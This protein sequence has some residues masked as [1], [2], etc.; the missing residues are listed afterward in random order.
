MLSSREHTDQITNGNVD[1]S[2]FSAEYLLAL[3]FFLNKE[4]SQKYNNF[5][6]LLVDV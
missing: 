6:G 1:A 3:F 5:L 4:K 2:L